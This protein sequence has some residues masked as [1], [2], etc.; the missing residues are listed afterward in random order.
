MKKGCFLVVIVTH[1]DRQCNVFFSLKIVF[2]W[3]EW[4]ALGH[5]ILL[6]LLLMM[7]MMVSSSSS[8]TAALLRMKE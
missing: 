2:S 3:E 4:F 8:A 5:T 1:T 6:L 7:M